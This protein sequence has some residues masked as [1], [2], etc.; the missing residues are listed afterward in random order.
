[1]PRIIDHNR[2]ETSRDG[3]RESYR[4]AL[5]LAKSVRSAIWRIDARSQPVD[6]KRSTPVSKLKRAY[7]TRVARKHR[8]STPNRIARNVI[9]NLGQRPSTKHHL[10]HIIPMSWFD[11]RNLNQVKTCW[12]VRNLRWVYGSEN[13]SKSNRLTITQFNRLISD[14]V[15]RLNAIKSASFAPDY[16]IKWVREAYQKKLIKNREP[17]QRT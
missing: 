4:K 15:W 12:D 8:T 6:P 11:H 2:P 3:Y 9:D 14:S 5:R 10:D 16:A 13:S 17:N 7:R 1:M